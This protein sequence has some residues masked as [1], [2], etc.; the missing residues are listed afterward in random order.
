MMM[1]QPTGHKKT[2]MVSKQKNTRCKRDSKRILAF[3]KRKMKAFESCA[4]A[5]LGRVRTAKADWT[6]SPAAHAVAGKI[7]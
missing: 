1:P 6:R 2:S 5:I 3:D 7:R 4:D